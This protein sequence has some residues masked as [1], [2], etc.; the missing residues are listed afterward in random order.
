MS[1][2]WTSSSPTWRRSG[3]S[4]FSATGDRRD[5]ALGA[6]LAPHAVVPGVSAMGND[7]VPR[8]VKDVSRARRRCTRSTTSTSRS[9]MASSLRC[10]GRPAAASRR[11]S[12]CSPA[13]RRA[14]EAT[15]TVRRR[16]VDA[17]RPRPRRGV[18]GAGAVSL[19]QRLGQRH[20]RAAACR[21][22]KRAEYGPRR[23]PCSSWS[24][25]KLSPTPCPRSSPAACASASASRA[26]W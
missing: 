3:C 23:A 11:C 10:S 16:P 7:R 25:S 26:C 4:A 5:R 18:P 1:G 22:L 8:H 24:A 9:R 21:A 12:T 13:S 19:A 14:P 2:A 20:F 17:A 15:L 6:G